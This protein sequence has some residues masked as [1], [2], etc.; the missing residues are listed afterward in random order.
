[1]CPILV[2]T[3]VAARCLDFPLID[4]VANYDLPDTSDSYIRRIDRAS[5]ADYLGKS[6]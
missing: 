2:A 6:I 4:F 5:H 3:F 1:Q